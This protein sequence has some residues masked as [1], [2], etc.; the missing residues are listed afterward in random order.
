MAALTGAVV[1]LFK[2]IL[3]LN[4]RHA[5]TREKLGEVSGKQAGIEALSKKVLLVVHEATQSNDVD[6]RDS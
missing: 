4:D 6:P 3:S 1:F 2:Q 5:E